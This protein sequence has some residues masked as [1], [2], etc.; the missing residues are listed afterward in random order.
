MEE[1][2]LEGK[3]GVRKRQRSRYRERGRETWGGGRETEKRDG[4]REERGG[5]TNVRTE[6]RGAGRG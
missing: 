6:M 4:K 1:R 2:G 3:G 5:M